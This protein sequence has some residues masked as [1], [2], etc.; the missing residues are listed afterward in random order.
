RGERGRRGEGEG[1]VRDVLEAREGLPYERVLPRER[2]PPELHLR[3]RQRLAEAAEGDGEAALG[4]ARG[5]L[6]LERER[7]EHLV[8]HERKPER[9]KEPMIVLL[10]IVAGR[11]VRADRD[12]G[13]A[14]FARARDRLAIEVEAVLE[15][16]RVG[17]ERHPRDAG[18]IVEE[19]I[20]RPWDEDP[21]A[22]VG[23]QAEEE[24]VGLA[25]AREEAE[26]IDGVIEVTSDGLASRLG[27][28]ALGLVP[29][30]W[31]LGVRLGEERTWRREPEPG[32][33]RTG[34]IEKGPTPAPRSLERDGEGVEVARA[35]APA[36]EH[37]SIMT[38][39]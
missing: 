34:E 30:E 3:E 23:E 12:D 39:V 33:V 26:A 35:V 11:V 4:R 28:E 16:E 5:C 38:S 9:Q 21:L 36:R 24:H 29:V 14:T 6:A 31:A 19:W 37:G 15:S 22:R 17:L 25:G 10:E 18:Q 13:A 8:D 2:H 7:A 1:R 27:P 32:R 20:T